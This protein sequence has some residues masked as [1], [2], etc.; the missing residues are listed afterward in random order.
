MSIFVK[1]GGGEDPKNKV[2][3]LSIEKYFDK[4]YDLFSKWD[5]LLHF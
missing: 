1:P 4:P 5:V 2:I 3:D